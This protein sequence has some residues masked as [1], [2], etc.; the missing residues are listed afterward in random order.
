[1][2][3]AIVIADEITAAGLRLAGAVTVVP[4][5]GEVA[6]ALRGRARGRRSWC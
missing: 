4:E 6:A 3:G 1:M 2:L 5:A